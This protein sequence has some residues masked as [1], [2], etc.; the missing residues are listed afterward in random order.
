MRFGKIAFVAVL[1]FAAPF[2]AQAITIQV[3]S[4]QTSVVFGYGALDSLGLAVA[5]T[6]GSVPGGL[7]PNS[8]GFGINSRNTFGDY[9]ETT[10]VYEAGDFAPFAGTIEHDGAIFLTDAATGT[11]AITV[12]DFTIGYDAGRADEGSG[13]T[14][15]YVQDNIDTGAILFDIAD[16]IV[17]AFENSLVIAANIL[18]SPEL[19]GLLNELGLIDIDASGVDAGAALVLGNSSIVPVPAAV[20]LFGSALGL[21]GWVRTRRV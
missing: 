7:G 14:G 21:L 18:V 13:A 20:W 10:F 11:A 15:F 9:L 5:G 2:S 17:E 8:V 3:D 19:S 12:G 4:G 16:P 1:L 6:T